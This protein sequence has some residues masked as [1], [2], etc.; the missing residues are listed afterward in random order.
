MLFVNL[1]RFI[2]GNSWLGPS[3][4]ASP[5]HLPQTAG[6]APQC[7][8]LSGRSL[9]WLGAPALL[10]GGRPGELGG[11]R[12]LGEGD[13]WPLEGCSGW[14]LPLRELETGGM[15]TPPVSATQTPALGRKG[16]EPVQGLDWDRPDSGALP[17]CSFW[18]HHPGMR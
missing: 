16:C 17:C 7:S 2:H 8:Q 3:R 6:S 13:V 14:T 11:R 1:L 10:R 5:A 4:V 15:R 12:G 9:G 18:S